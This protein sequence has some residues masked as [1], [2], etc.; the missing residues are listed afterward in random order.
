MK[1]RKPC[2][3][4]WIK[5]NQNW[6]ISI[7]PCLHIQQI[8]LSV[9]LLNCQS[10][11]LSHLPRYPELQN[12][13]CWSHHTP[14]QLLGCLYRIHFLPIIKRT[15][16]IMR[17]LKNNII[18]WSFLCIFCSTTLLV[19]TITVRT[20]SLYVHTT[21]FG[22]LV[23]H[24]RQRNSDVSKRKWFDSRSGNLI[25]PVFVLLLFL[26]DTSEF[27]SLWQW[28]SCSKCILHRVRW[29]SCLTI[30]RSNSQSERS[31]GKCLEIS[32]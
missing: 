23:H 7:V 17:T 28:T 8:Q 4:S 18:T 21:H 6:W 3:I 25:F 11:S 32:I 22:Q 1:A 9:D 31:G 27:L 20:V 24:Q 2:F 19:L 14:K 10:L 29:A 26:L 15:I 30:N 5:N 16:S 12:F 13:L